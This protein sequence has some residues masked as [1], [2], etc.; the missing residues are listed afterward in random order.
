MKKKTVLL[1]LLFAMLFSLCSCGAPKTL[2]EACQKADQLV[3]KWDRKG[4]NVS[5][6]E[7]HYSKNSNAYIVTTYSLTAADETES[8]KE[9][10]ARRNCEF[11]YDGLKDIFSDFDV[12]IAVIM[13]DENQ[14]A[15]YATI[16][17]AYVN[18]G[19]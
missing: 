10:V 17:G 2:D 5:G 3:G 18:V 7:G 1:L 12:H 6:Y 19:G 9:F 4:T 8:A 13:V 16:D 15:Y 11:V 14:N